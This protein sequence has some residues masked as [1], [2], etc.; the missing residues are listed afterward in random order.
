[1]AA[2]IGR[3][4][5]PGVEGPSTR[6]ESTT[7]RARR[8]VVGAVVAAPAAVAAQAAVMRSYFAISWSWLSLRS[9]SSGMQST[10]QTCWHW[11]SS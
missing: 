10:G 5:R 8:G 2:G 3:C 4:K 11:G 9:G 6:P 7:P 1:M